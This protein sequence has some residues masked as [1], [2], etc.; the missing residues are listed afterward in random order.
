MR[1]RPTA[2]AS[3]APSL[4]HIVPRALRLHGFV[5]FSWYRV[6]RLNRSRRVDGRLNNAAGG[7]VLG[8]GPIGH[9]RRVDGAEME[10]AHAVYI[11]ERQLGLRQRC[12]DTNSVSA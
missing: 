11:D 5:V 12:D 7:G 1:P 3:A 6:C 4:S 9:V 10:T 2:A 8:V